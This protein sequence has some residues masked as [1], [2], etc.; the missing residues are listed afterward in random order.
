MPQGATAPMNDALAARRQRRDRQ[1]LAHSWQHAYCAG[2]HRE[3]VELLKLDQAVTTGTVTV[4]A[5]ADAVAELRR[6]QQHRHAA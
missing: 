2:S 1:R 5:A 3:R 6:A 4:R